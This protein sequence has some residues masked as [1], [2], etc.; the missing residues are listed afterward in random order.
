M[1][2]QMNAKAFDRLTIL[3]R[4]AHGIAKHCR[5]FT[6]YVWMCQLDAQKGID[7]GTTY[8]TD[9]KC[10]EFIDAIAEIE[11]QKLEETTKKVKFI[12]ISCDEATD[13]AIMEQL[14]I[15]IRYA[16][17]GEIKTDFLAIKTLDRATANNCYS[18]ILQS[19]NEQCNIDP[20]DLWHKLV[21]FT[22]D[23]ASVMQGVR[24]GVGAQLKEN[25]PKL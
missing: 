23:G 19:F 20:V 18:A 5:P 14:I 16:V 6:D 8:M 15:Y 7:I 10:R 17:A 12:S 11:R 1:V 2:G 24:N 25:Q 3:F 13:S 22:S 9:I 21:G 4:N